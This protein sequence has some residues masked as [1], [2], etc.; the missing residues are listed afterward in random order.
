MPVLK[1]QGLAKARLS[2]ALIFISLVML[3]GS[4]SAQASQSQALETCQNLVHV[5][6][7]QI[8]APFLPQNQIQTLADCNRELIELYNP[9]VVTEPS[10]RLDGFDCLSGQWVCQATDLLARG[11]FSWFLGSGTYVN[12]IAGQ[13][14]D[15]EKRRFERYVETFPDR[16]A[17]G[18]TSRGAQALIQTAYEDFHH[19]HPGLRNGLQGLKAVATDYSYHYTL[20]ELMGVGFDP[21]SEEDLSRMEVIARG[22]QDSL[23]HCFARTESIQGV[24]TCVDLA[25]V[26]APDRVGRSALERNIEALFLSELNSQQGSQLL[27]TARNDLEE[28]LPTFYFNQDIEA[29][30]NKKMSACVFYSFLNSFRWV[31]E[32]TLQTSLG[33]SLASTQ[34]AQRVDQALGSCEMNILFDSQKQP[35]EIQRELLAWET[36]DLEAG[37]LSC[38]T[39]V[40]EHLAADIIE[41]MLRQEPLLQQFLGEEIDSFIA[42]VLNHHYPQ[43]R[44]GLRDLDKADHPENCESYLYVQTVFDLV[45][46]LLSEE[47]NKQLESLLGEGDHSSTIN[48]LLASAEH[49]LSRC[50]LEVSQNSLQHPE[51]ERARWDVELIACLNQAVVV[52]SQNLVTQV[53]PQELARNPFIQ[54]YNISVNEEIIAQSAESFGLCMGQA[55][56]EESHLASYPEQLEVALGSCRL[57]SYKNIIAEIMDQILESELLRAGFNYNIL[58]EILSDYK[59]KPGNLYE[60]IQQA[61]DQESLDS[62]TASADQ[63]VL[64]DLAPLLITQLVKREAGHFLWPAAT[65]NVVEL[66]TRRFLDCIID[67]DISVCQQQAM[68]VAIE[69]ILWWILPSEVEREFE[70]AA[71]HH[72]SPQVIRELGVREIVFHSFSSPDGRPLIDYIVHEMMMGGDIDEISQTYEFRRNLFLIFARNESFLDQM[73]EAI[74]QPHMDADIARR[75]SQSPFHWLVINVFIPNDVQQWRHIKNTPSGQWVEQRFLQILEQLITE[76]HRSIT[77][78]D[79]QQ[80]AERVGQAA[81]EWLRQRR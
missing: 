1:N 41:Q 75:S 29:P 45:N 56:A 3:L 66:T 54:D 38:Q 16:V 58:T 70:A 22:L 51:R 40:T 65:E 80:L 81:R 49:A 35:L 37:L 62:L 47:L 32:A 61:P 67:Q 71:I 6:T 14:S 8:Q 52:V 28:C 72:I 23:T 53:I 12:L 15:K 73:L 76:P 31:V 42:R 60:Q 36:E 59:Q 34:I 25:G 30:L 19:Q 69:A 64:T 4:L 20:S 55:L 43:C 17:E 13:L 11:G 48:A 46:S 5:R 21:E 26:Y 2:I 50:K 39:Q 18:I 57:Q 78:Q 27:V 10:V 44:Q 33:E 63:V 68:P 77:S 79:M 24:M 74:V 9:S 7:L